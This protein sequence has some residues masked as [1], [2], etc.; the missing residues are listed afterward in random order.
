MELKQ[1]KEE[2]QTLTNTI[3]QLKVAIKAPLN[4][5]VKDK[6]NENC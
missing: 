5:Q 3:E 6:S 4:P 2:R 1:L